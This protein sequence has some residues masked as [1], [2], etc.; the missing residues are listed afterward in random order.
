MGSWTLRPQ[1]TGGVNGS[2]NAADRA[3]Q[4]VRRHGWQFHGAGVEEAVRDLGEAME[5]MRRELEGVTV[6]LTSPITE[7]AH[8][9]TVVG[10]RG[11]F[12][13]RLYC[14]EHRPLGCIPVTAADVTASTD[15]HECGAGLLR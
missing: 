14:L 3:A 11:G 6:A 1:A 12:P 7:T 13:T 15:C 2:F 9:L 8:G 10:W 5:S 4:Y